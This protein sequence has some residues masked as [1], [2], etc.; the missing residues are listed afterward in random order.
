[1]GPLKLQAVMDYRLDAMLLA[2][3]LKDI[4]LPTGCQFQACNLFDNDAWRDALQATPRTPENVRKSEFYHVVYHKVFDAHLFSSP[5]T[6][7]GQF[8]RKP[9]YYLTAAFVE[10]GLD[11]ESVDKAIVAMQAFKDSLVKT[12]TQRVRLDRSVRNTAGA[13]FRSLGKRL[14][15]PSPQKRGGI[16]RFPAEI[17][18]H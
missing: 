8:Y 17:S 6:Q 16:P 2:T 5:T 3:T 10:S 12:M 14:R 9:N 18:S 4:G 13:A 1:M 7:Q 15:S 11:E